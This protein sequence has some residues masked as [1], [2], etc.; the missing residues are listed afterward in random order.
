[1]AQVAKSTT[2]RL[3][4]ITEL[5]GSFSTDDGSCLAAISLGEGLVSIGVEALLPQLL[6][7][8]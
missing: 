5:R 3:V 7:D 2:A 8:A 1:V 6:L 4:D